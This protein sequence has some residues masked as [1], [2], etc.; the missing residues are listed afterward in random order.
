MPTYRGVEFKAYV[1]KDVDT[2]EFLGKFT[3]TE[4]KGNEVIDHKERYVTPEG[5]DDPAKFKTEQ[6]A[7]EATEQ[8]AIQA[9]DRL[10]DQKETKGRIPVKQVLRNLTG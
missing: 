8:V 6:E 4:H 10:L 2:G 5:G 1:S 3:L 9:I 7:K